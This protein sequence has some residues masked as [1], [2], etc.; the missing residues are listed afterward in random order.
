M[1]AGRVI[2]PGRPRGKTY[3]WNEGQVCISINVHRRDNTAVESRTN[4]RSINST[5]VSLHIMVRKNEG[6]SSDNKKEVCPFRDQFPVDF[7][8]NIASHFSLVMRQPISRR[9]IGDALSEENK[10]KN[11][12]S[13]NVK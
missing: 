12:A 5:A 13:A 7:M 3:A 6:K 8:K 10:W 11:L 9:Y 2:Q 4:E 1:A